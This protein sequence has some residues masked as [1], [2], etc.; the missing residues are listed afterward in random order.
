MLSNFYYKRGVVGLVVVEV[1]S[2]LT[3]E[4]FCWV[5]KVVRG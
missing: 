2:M 5:M 1:G 3:I 4:M